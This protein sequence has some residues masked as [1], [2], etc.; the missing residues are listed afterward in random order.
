[1]VLLAS[2]CG[3]GSAV[4]E[5]G[6]VADA[7]DQAPRSTV[8]EPATT[9]STPSAAVTKPTAPTEPAPPATPAAYPDVVASTVAGGQLDLGSLQG[10]DIVLWFW[11]PW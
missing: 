9:N 2:A 4:S 11:A 8:S 6:A 3:S 10:Q 1:M 7:A 5:T